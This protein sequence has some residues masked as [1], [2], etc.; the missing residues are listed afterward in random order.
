MTELARSEIEAGVDL[1]VDDDTATDAGAERD[2]DAVLRSACRS[3]ECLCEGGGVGVV[4]DVD[5]RHGEVTHELA[6]DLKMTERQVAGIFDDG[7]FPV[8]YPG[9]GDACIGD[10]GKRDARFGEEIPGELRHVGDD[11][12]CTAL[13]QGRHAPFPDDLHGFIHDT[14]GNVGAAEVNSDIIHDVLLLYDMLIVSMCRTGRG[15]P[16]RR[17]VA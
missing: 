7:G 11:R 15:Y 8:A 16:H 14:D 5:L 4:L 10:L 12:F 17:S 3:G 6:P 2:H 1:A 9:G 13:G